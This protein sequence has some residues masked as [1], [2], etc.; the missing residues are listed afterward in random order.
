MMWN[1]FFLL[2]CTVFALSYAHGRVLESEE[3]DVVTCG[4]TIKLEHVSSGFRLHSH[5]VTYGSGSG[6]QS[7]TGFPG[8]NDPNSLW[9]IRA[10]HGNEDCQ[11]GK[12]LQENDVIRL[13][14]V[15]TK[16]LLH[17]HLHQAPLS[18]E[19][20][21]SC[22][23]TAGFGDHSDNWRII[24]SATG[25]DKRWLR[26]QKV[27]FQHVDTGRYLAITDKT[28]RNPIPGQREVAAVAKRTVKTAFQTA[29]GFYFPKRQE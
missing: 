15:N 13:E 8:A 1:S 14:H 23:G 26:K 9:V 3:H 18:P 20:E 12:P 11:Q 21:V 17:S 29:E 19:Q 28:F 25:E 7:V 6:Q 4:S 22:Y 16:C 2:F 10:A 24:L 27:Y 5:Q